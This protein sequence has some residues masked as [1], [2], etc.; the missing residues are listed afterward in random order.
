M[1][2]IT[3]LLSILSPLSH[4][5]QEQ[6]PLAQLEPVAPKSVE[7]ANFYTRQTDM[8]GREAAQK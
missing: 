5:E 1:K 7:S 2:K 4:I 3:Q 8:G 6:L